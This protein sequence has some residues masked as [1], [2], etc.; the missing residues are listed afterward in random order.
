MDM[1]TVRNAC[2]AATVGMLLTCP[3]V[4][5]ADRPPKSLDDRF[6]EI[7]RLHVPG[8]GG[9]Y[10]DAEG[11]LTV[12]L[13]DQ[14]LAASAQSYVAGLLE[15]V[16]WRGGAKI[17]PQAVVTVAGSYGFAELSAWRDSLLQVDPAIGIV[18]LDVDERANRVA[19]AVTSEAARKAVTHVIA[20]KGLPV[21]AIDVFMSDAIQPLATLQ[22]EFRP[23]RAGVQIRNNNGGICTKGPNVKVADP[24]RPSGFRYSFI[25]NSHCTN[26]TGGGEATIIY[27]SGG[28][29]FGWDRIGVEEEDPVYEP[30]ITG[31]PVGR[32]CRRSD[33][34]RISF[35]NPSM[36]GGYRD[37]QG[38]AN[39]CMLPI[40]H[41]DLTTT[42]AA[43]RG[44][45]QTVA[46][47]GDGITKT[48]RTSGTTFGFVTRIGVIGNVAG[49]THSLLN[50][51]VVNAFADHGD[52]GSPAYSWITDYQ[53]LFVGLLWGG[54][55]TEYWFST[56]EDIKSELHLMT[57]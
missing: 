40:T 18:F 24:T 50:Q 49:S 46:I 55:A 14:N 15:Q 5:A 26:V 29:W 17:A 57:W 51:S 10:V 21:D 3:M 53:Q 43:I 34:A 7:D 41:C 20:S 39:W 13:K 47:V 27:Q 4:F 37:V 30:N 2:A 12:V 54:T 23:P 9:L 8:F 16:G 31:C 32:S 19:V 33:S 45:G 36:A 28:N 35:D 1:K 25:T 56:Y 38:T 44:L 52:S 48:G 22:D 11:K 42:N 6:I